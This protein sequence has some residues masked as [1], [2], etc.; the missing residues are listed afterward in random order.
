[1]FSIVEFVNDG[2]SFV[3]TIWIEQDEK[4][5]KWP[6]DQTKCKLYR[7]ECYSPR[8]DWKTFDIKRIFCTASKLHV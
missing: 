2:V 3:P 6:S 7:K 1:M 4:K 5:C 8:S